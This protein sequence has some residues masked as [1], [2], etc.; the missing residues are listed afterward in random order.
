MKS[1]WIRY[2]WLATMCQGGHV[3]GQYNIIFS[4]R[5]YMKIGFSSQRREM[6]LF[7]TLTHH[8]HGCCD[9]MC[10]LALYEQQWLRTGTSRSNASSI[11]PGQLAERVWSAKSQSSLLNIYFSVSGLQSSLLIIRLIKQQNGNITWRWERAQKHDFQCP[12]CH[13]AIG[14]AICLICARR[15]W[16]TFPFVAKS[17][18]SPTATTVQIPV[19]TAPKW[20]TESIRY[21][22]LLFQ[23]QH[24]A[25]LQHYRNHAKII[26]LMCEQKP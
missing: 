24:S 16:L 20:G 8:Q 19:H 3:G 17:V 21:V 22:M 10:N 12:I 9:I 26:I 18:Y 25:A 14:Q 6:L 23:D 7:L 5:I 13:S 2:S 15:C 11:V 1:Y 4:W